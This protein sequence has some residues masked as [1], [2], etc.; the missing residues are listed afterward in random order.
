[1]AP[2]TGDDRVNLLGG[3][4]KCLTTVAGIVIAVEAGLYALNKGTESWRV[5]C[6]ML[7]TM[8]LS[9]ALPLYGSV[10]AILD[11][12]EE[13]GIDVNARLIIDHGEYFFMLSSVMALFLVLA[14]LT[15]LAFGG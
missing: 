13:Q 8:G 5:P 12:M 15:I 14:L 1:M 9:A 6:W 7:L 4:V 10:I 11:M 2:L 3:V